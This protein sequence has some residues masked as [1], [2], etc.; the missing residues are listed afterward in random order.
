M[1]KPITKTNNNKHGKTAFI[2]RTFIIICFVLFWELYARN[3]TR[4]AFYTSYPSDII[5]DLIKFA[6][7]GDMF[8]HIGITLKE[9]YLGLL[10]G[11]IVA[12]AAGVV[13]SQFS[14]VGKIFVPVISAIQGI[15]QLTLAPLYILWF[16]I[17]I[18]SKIALA[19]YFVPVEQPSRKTRAHTSVN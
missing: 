1:E 3:N 19:E 17:G 12:I 10:Y 15:P 18:K 9:A 11:S 16:G 5:A 7:S 4:M 8:R 6:A 13:F 14:T 2:I